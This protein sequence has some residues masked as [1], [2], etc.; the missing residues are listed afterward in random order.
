MKIYYGDGILPSTDNLSF[1][2]IGSEI[3]GHSTFELE[4]RALREFHLSD[5]IF[6]KTLCGGLFVLVAHDD[7]AGKFCV[8]EER[9]PRLRHDPKI[10]EALKLARWDLEDANSL[11][12]Q[13]QYERAKQAHIR[14]VNKIQFARF[15]LHRYLQQKRHVASRP[16]L[17]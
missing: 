12:N 3:A 17:G 5:D 14:A 10:V 4:A 7:V 8:Y 2:R 9:I 13:Y 15:T 16:S 11:L 1:D 6:P